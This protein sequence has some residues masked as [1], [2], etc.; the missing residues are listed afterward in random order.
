MASGTRTRTRSRD[1]Q[2]NLLDAAEAV[3]ARE[4]LAGV[5]IRAVAAEAGVAPMGVYN[6]FGSKDGLIAALVMRS[7]DLL[8]EAVCRNDDHLLEILQQ[9]R[10]VKGVTS[11][12]AFVYLK[13]RKQTYSWGTA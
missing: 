11:A 13:L 7:F 1:V 12:E 2:Q 10:S 6:R 5:T 4:G 9:I 8:T 3:L